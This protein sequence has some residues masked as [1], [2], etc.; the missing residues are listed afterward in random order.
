MTYH[1][2]A[3][4][5]EALAETD[6]ARFEREVAVG[7]RSGPPRAWVEAKKKQEER[8]AMSKKEKKGRKGGL[9][10]LQDARSGGSGGGGGGGGGPT[11]ARGL[12]AWNCFVA[13]KSSTKS[14]L[15]DLGVM[16]NALAPAEKQVCAC[17]RVLV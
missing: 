13:D 6:R 12:S 10:K 2:R 16:W 17:M 3:Q 1:V 4:P 15:K 5:Y 14:S 9:Q 7:L 8:V 11:P